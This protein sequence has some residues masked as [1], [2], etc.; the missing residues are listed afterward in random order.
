MQQHNTWCVCMCP[1]WK[2]MLTADHGE[3]VKFGDIPVWQC[4]FSVV[5]Q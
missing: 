1:V 2:G 3:T 5:S 4:W